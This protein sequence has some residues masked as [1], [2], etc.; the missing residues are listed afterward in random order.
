[1]QAVESSDGVLARDTLLDAERVP[2]PVRDGMK[3]TVLD[4]DRDAESE[5]DRLTDAD[6]DSLAKRDSETDGDAVTLKPRVGDVE[7]DRVGE[8]SVHSTKRRKFV[9]PP[10]PPVVLSA[11]LGVM[12]H[13]FRPKHDAF[14][15]APLP[16]APGHEP[17]A[18]GPDGHDPV[19]LP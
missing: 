6:K 1:M 7:R 5:V 12:E 16:A 2:L 3:P 18:N 9:W 4:A 10:Q 15:I 19:G 13:E 17:S 8:I 14:T 11:P